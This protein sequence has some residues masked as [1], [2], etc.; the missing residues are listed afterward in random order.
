MLPN[1]KYDNLFA[2]LYYVFH[3]LIDFNDSIKN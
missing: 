2:N 3:S 1:V